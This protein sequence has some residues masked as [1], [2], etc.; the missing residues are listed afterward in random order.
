MPINITPVLRVALPSQTLYLAQ[1]SRWTPKDTFKQVHLTEFTEFNFD[2]DS[3]HR[4]DDLSMLVLKQALREPAAFTMPCSAEH[5]TSTTGYM[6]LRAGHR[7]LALTLGANYVASKA[8][9]VS[10]MWS[11]VWASWAPYA[12]LLLGLHGE[13]LMATATTLV[14]F[15]YSCHC[16]TVHLYFI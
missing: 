13:A 12:P 4:R 9:Q 3:Q 6:E 2:I 11:S 1:A 14:E 8:Q 7:M 15:P 10:P 5:L 16:F